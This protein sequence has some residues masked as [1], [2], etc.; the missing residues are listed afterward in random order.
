MTTAAPL[1][2]R[3]YQ[4]AALDS[5]RMKYASGSRKVL[6]WLPTGAGKTVIFCRVLA[7]AI[8]KARHAIMVVRGAALVDQASQRLLRE[9]INHGCLQAG[10]WNVNPSAKIQ[11]CSIDTLF[12]RKLTPPA[13]LIVIDEA[14]LATSQ[15]FLW[16]FAQYP[17]AYYLPV[18][19]T[20][21]VR[22]GL[23]HIADDIVHP[24][25]FAE[26][27][28][29]GYLAKPRYFAPTKLNL[30]DV[31]TD[32]KTG[33][34]V[35]A[36][37]AAVMDGAAIYGDVVANYRDRVKGP[38]VLFA[39][40][41][42][43]SLM[44]RDRFRE[45]GFRAEH[46]EANTPDGERKRVLR[47]LE[48]GACQ[49]VTN[50]GILTTGV[51]MPELRAVILCRATKS[52]NLFVQMVGRGTR[53][54]PDKREFIVLDHANNVAAHGFVEQEPVVDLDGV[55]SKGKC[56]EQPCQCESCYGC[57]FPGDIWSENNPELAAI[58]KSGR[59]YVCPYCGHN[60]QATRAA[61]ERKKDEDIQCALREIESAKQLG[62]IRDERAIEKL[63]QTA[64]QRGHKGAWVKHRLIEKFGDSDG[65]THWEVVKKRFCDAR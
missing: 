61:Y 8:A 15:S 55:P 39:V 58:G 18:T 32:S 36:D 52:Y 23:R 63:I 21:F 59:D 47:D 34:Y 50:V 2:L 29:Q 5:I 31:R 9:G 6:L 53:V 3:P 42:K 14:H 27:I 57:F 41:I 26:L 60:N 65:Q 51:D 44:I 11:V 12:R 28:E 7:G 33:D 38:A 49:V 17:N 4:V 64:L 19:A 22:K 56:D 13:D 37:L 24:I 48:T 30:D 20:P 25:T 43:H 54:T 10:H 35:A 62:S 1:E 40:D 46:V 45:A 16:L